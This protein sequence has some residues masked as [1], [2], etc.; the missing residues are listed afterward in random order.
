M[1]HVGQSLFALSEER[2]VRTP[3]GSEPDNVREF[4]KSRMTTSATESKP[5]RK[6]DG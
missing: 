6:G 4:G 1:R 2:K 5:A 3:E